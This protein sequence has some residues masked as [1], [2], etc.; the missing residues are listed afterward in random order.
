MGADFTD[1]IIPK[2]MVHFDVIMTL[3]HKGERM[4]AVI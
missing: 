2:Y 1:D 4:I 3:T